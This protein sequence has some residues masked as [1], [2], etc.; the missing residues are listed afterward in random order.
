[1]EYMIFKSGK[2]FFIAKE[3]SDEYITYSDLFGNPWNGFKTL[4]ECV[5]YC[6]NF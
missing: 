2:A 1:M 5:N 6:N 4:V 3:D